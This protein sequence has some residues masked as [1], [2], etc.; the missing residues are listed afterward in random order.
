VQ[1]LRH[2]TARVRALA[3]S[4]DGRTLAIAAGRSRRI[5]LWD[6]AAGNARGMLQGHF[7]QV[8]RLA[9][10]RRGGLLASVDL[11]GGLR[12]WSAD[13]GQLRVAQQG[14]SSD[15]PLVFAPD[16]RT[17][18][19]AAAGVN[20]LDPATGKGKPPLPQRGFSWV[21]ALAYSPDGRTLAVSTWDSTV[22]LW[23]PVARRVRG[24]FPCGRRSRR[25]GP[26]GLVYAPDG[27]TLAVV[28]G[29]EVTLWEPH[30]RVTRA[31]LKGHGGVVTDAAY[32]PDGRLLVTASYDAT[33]R[34]WD[35]A[36]GRLLAVYDLGIGRVY[37]VALA[38]DGM[39]AF[40]GGDRDVAAWD[41]DPG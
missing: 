38:P 20:L 5:A 29:W 22:R 41:V 9:F 8:T 11:H 18:A 1:L 23:D 35:A 31:V 17:L 25:G 15:A 4:P 24:I 14:L 34:T 21:L 13:T 28:R 10:S 16:G 3:V 2:H 32:S 7:A 30:T 27:R 6:A 19:V 26:R 40:A 33:V 39:R 12:L 36:T 37:A